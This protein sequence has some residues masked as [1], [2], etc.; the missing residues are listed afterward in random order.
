M[1]KENNEPSR[2]QY[3]K[4]VIIVGCVIAAVIA[5]AV[6]Y[7][8]GY[9]AGVASVE[10]LPETSSEITFNEDISEPEVISTPSE[11]ITLSGAGQTA[12]DLIELTSGLATVK[13]KH[14]GESNFIITVLHQSGDRIESLVNEIG[15]FDGSK[16]FQVP[17]SGKYL[18]DVS[19]DGP[20]EVSIQ[21]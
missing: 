3:D 11:P 17:S 19:A 18:L 13:M 20:W 5:A 21:Q 12:T 10:E 6:V 8:A 1:T 15:F 9:G 7:Q 2:M 16:A 4:R 14:S